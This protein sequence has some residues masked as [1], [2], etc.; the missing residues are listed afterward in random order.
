MVSAEVSAQTKVT[1]KL[2]I[3][4]EVQVFSGFLTAGA[5]VFGTK[6]CTQVCKQSVRPQNQHR[7]QKT[8]LWF[9]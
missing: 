2:T 8:Q 9:K 3:E 7:K 6:P 5:G 1:E 4:V